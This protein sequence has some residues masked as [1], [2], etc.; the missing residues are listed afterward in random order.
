M[1]PSVNPV[2]VG[3]A[4]DN[5]RDNSSFTDMDIGNR[6]WGDARLLRREDCLRVGFWNCGG[7][8][9][10]NQDPKNRMLRNWILSNNFDVVGLSEVNVHWKALQNDQ[11]LPE[12]TNGWFESLHLSMAYLS[13]WPSKTPYQVGGSTL[14]SLNR[15]AHRVSNKGWDTSGMGRWC[16]T[17]YRGKHGVT[18]RIVSAYRCVHNVT[19]PLSAWSQQRIMLQKKGISEDPRQCFIVDFLNEV[20]SWLEQGEHLVIGLDLNEDIVTSAFT[21]QLAQFG[22]REI[23]CFLHDSPPPTYLRGSTAIDG[24]YVSSALT[25]SSCGYLPFLGD[26]RPSWIDIS[27]SSLFGEAAL[28]SSRA[29]RLQLNDPRTVQRY[30]EFLASYTK[31]HDLLG[32]AMVLSESERPLYSLTN[33][34]NAIDNLRTKGMRLAEK[35]CRKLKM[36][37][38]SFCP[39]YSRI[40]Q[41]V[42]VWKMIYKRKHG[43]SVDSR[44]YSRKLHQVGLERSWVNSLSLEEVDAHR[45]TAYRQLNFFSRTATNSRNLWLEDVANARSTIS[46]LSSEQELRNMM[47]REA[48]RREARII[49]AT[50][51]SSFS[52]GLPLIQFSGLDGITETS[53]K[54]EMEQGL[55]DQLSARFHQASHTPFASEPLLSLVGPLGTSEGATQ[56][57]HGTFQCPVS[58]DEWTRKLIPHLAFMDNVQLAQAEF[59]LALS[60]KEHSE[61]W[62][63]MKEKTSCGLSA[64]SFAQF[65][66]ATM[67]AT[68]CSLDTILASLPYE[69][70]LSPSRWQQ[71]VDVM[72]QKQPGNY[73]VDKLRA[74]LLYEADFNQNNKR[75][76]RQVMYLAE[77][78]NALAVEQFGSRKGMSAIDQSL[79]KALT[80]DLWRQLKRPGAIC[81]NDAK[82]C[83]D[84]IVHNFA[85][86]CLQRLGAPVAPIVSMFSTIQNLN[87]HIRTIH[88]DSTISF[89]G[90]NWNTP[91][92]GVGQ[93]NGAGP[94]IWAAVSTPLLNMVRS[95]GGGAQFCSSISSQSLEFVGYAFVDD[96]DL[97]AS[98]IT[99]TSSQAVFNDLQHSL[100]AWQGGIHA[101]GGAIVPEKSHWYLIDFSWSNGKPSYKPTSS[102]PVQLVVKDSAGVLQP[103]RQ[104][105]PWEAE[106]TLG[107]RLAPDGNMLAQASYMVQQAVEWSDKIRVG[108]FNRALMSQAL[109]TTIMKSL[110]YVLPATTLS[111]TQ[112]DQIMAPILKYCLPRIGVV[113][114]FPR[115]LVHAVPT[116]HG[117]N[118]PKLYWLQGFYHIDRLL[119]F[120]RSSHITGQL[121]NH[122]LEALRLE[123]GC[124][125]SIFSLPFNTVGHLATSSW[126]SQTWAFLS[127]YRLTL[128]IEVP[129]LTL[130][131]VHDALLIPTF[132]AKGYKGVELD[133]LNRCRMFLQ[134]A[135]LS[136]ITTGCGTRISRSSQQGSVDS[137][138]VSLYTW[139]RQSNPP[140]SFWETWREALKSLCSSDWTLQRPLGEWLSVVSC[141]FFYDPLSERI[142][143]REGQFTF[144]YSR[145]PSRT[146][147]SN[148]SRFGNKQATAEWPATC[149]PATV[150]IHRTFIY[151]TGFHSLQYSQA[152]TPDSFFDYL[153]T[154]LPTSSLWALQHLKFIG[155]LPAF[156]RI[157]TTGSVSLYAVS[158]GSFKDN[159]GTACWRISLPSSNDYFLGSVHVPGPPGCQSAF[160]SELAG[161]YGIAI[162]LWAIKNFY[163]CEI[164]ATIGCDGLSAL[165][166][167][168][169]NSDVINPNSA[170]FDLIFATRHILRLTSGQYTWRHIK[171][172]QDEGGNTKLDMWALFNIQMDMAAKQFWSTGTQ[173]VNS[174]YNDTI[175]GEPGIFRIQN[176]KIVVDLKLRLLSY[177]CSLQAIPFWENHFGW[178]KGS[179]Q[180][181]NWKSIGYSSQALKSARRLWI[182]KHCSGFFASGKMMTRWKFQQDPGCPRC[183]FPMEDAIHIIKCPSTEATTIW[184]KSMITLHKFLVARPTPSTLADVICDRLQYWKN[185]RDL[186]ALPD[187][188]DRSYSNVVQEQDIFGWEAFLQGFWSPLW[189][190][191]ISGYLQSIQSK[192]MVK[193]WITEI[194]R[195]LWNIS[196]D[197]WEHR[198]SFVHDKEQGRLVR[199]L[200]SSITEQYALG[201]ASLARVDRALFR[202]SLQ[203][204]LNSSI[205]HKQMWVERVLAARQ[206]SVAITAEGQSA[207]GQERR[208]LSNWLQRTG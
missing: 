180:K 11:R 195:H 14:L 83:Y 89:T 138:R 25:H 112:C 40:S 21:A 207:Y 202:R 130:F 121:L 16:W 75:F 9:Q 174:E 176:E 74:I 47:H 124:N 15:M 122:S 84:R 100:N 67:E 154:S 188:L 110:E 86:I 142:Y 22:V 39:E 135:S 95:E 64:L 1:I 34:Y 149:L 117:L 77:K 32:R 48:Q 113:R 23:N 164:S 91:I 170:Q 118:L 198:N 116:Y 131:R 94:Q 6:N 43:G 162:T 27:Y 90:K 41:R 105:E 51:H 184:N 165:L 120:T 187:S 71:G 189:E 98:T 53:K 146:S 104:L 158:D 31:D 58:V 166:L 8:P 73:L 194:I 203:S 82:S 193:R 205:T 28:L 129:D 119:R 111:K 38:T 206:R 56:I 85:S 55:I 69:L 169:E 127:E 19:G 128:H 45:R 136:D 125:G 151:L 132:I 153:R 20:Q 2:Q 197:L 107:V 30:V 199:F 181:I 10:S 183:P 173:V 144:F 160:R 68:L 109:V 70:G 152:N 87:H 72:L 66:A 13:D 62:K 167:C 7:L 37:A 147:R 54:D 78:Y 50:L 103:L 36:G 4:Q 35:Q 175:F 145:C 192:V 155:D 24:I 148:T 171:G 76:G 52:S 59:H 80:F 26:H 191:V 133:Q 168:Q 177:L 92:H 46:G 161:L 60:A 5:D 79:N 140:P 134:V 33:E 178:A 106:R 141:Q 99:A 208:S 97:V 126:V 139:P 29:R 137:T 115:A 179:G 114:S 201:S 108:S 157:C 190:E 196:W 81:S 204:T 18:V 123:V 159:R 57:L 42:L 101:S 12:R 156:A 185:G 61:G 88:G 150:D 63:K 186:P 182:S 96:T 93:G 49:K 163:N 44:Y 65:K 172:H 200:N 102:L 143:V 3:I 17:T